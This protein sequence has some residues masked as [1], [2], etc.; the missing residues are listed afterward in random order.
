MKFRQMYKKIEIIFFFLNLTCL[1][2]IEFFCCCRKC[3]FYSILKKFN[4]PYPEILKIIF[5]GLFSGS[6]FYYYYYYYFFCISNLRI[7]KNFDFNP[8]QFSK[9]DL[10]RSQYKNEKNKIA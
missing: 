7:F 6:H 4:G 8:P 2:I 9:I 5:S 10:N 3:V 1:K